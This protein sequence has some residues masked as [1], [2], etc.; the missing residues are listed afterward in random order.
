[1]VAVLATSE[2]KVKLLTETVAKRRD[3]WTVERD[4]LNRE[5]DAIQAFEVVTPYKCAK[6][7]RPSSSTNY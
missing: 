6:E 4:W 2:E 7:I 3:D 5:K 1:V